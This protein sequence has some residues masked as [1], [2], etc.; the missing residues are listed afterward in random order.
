M[1]IEEIYGHNPLE[2]EKLHELTEMYLLRARTL[3][4]QG[5][6]KKGVKFMTKHNKYIVDDQR[7]NELLCKLYLAN[8]QTKKAIEHYEFLVQLNSSNKEYFLGLL[9]ANNVDLTN[10]EQ[11]LEHINQYE[12]LLPKSN[13]HTRLA[14]DLLKPGPQFEEK[15][16]KYM[17]PMV[18]KGVPSIITELKS[19]YKDQG[20]VEIIENYLK[21]M[22][23]NMEKGMV[24]DP[25]ED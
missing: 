21:S 25:S 13:T 2:T 20:K 16:K 8:N 3:F 1:S 15:L 7:K 10:E 11:V 5:E 19:L 4:E 22:L 18:I 24:L 6:A 14:L 23:E 12:S 17:R 9:K